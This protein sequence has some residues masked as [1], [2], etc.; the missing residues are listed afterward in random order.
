MRRR[1]PIPLLMYLALDNP[2]RQGIGAATILRHG[3]DKAFPDEKPK[4]R[5]LVFPKKPETLENE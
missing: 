5:R 1:R 2:M 4:R 3:W